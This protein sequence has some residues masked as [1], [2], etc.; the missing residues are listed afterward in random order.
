M[1]LNVLSTA[2][3]HLRTISHKS[4]HTQKLTRRPREKEKERQK[5]EETR[6]EPGETGK[7]KRDRRGGE[8]G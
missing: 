7:R 8:T 5:R 4:I 3:G 1:D 2:E 6:W